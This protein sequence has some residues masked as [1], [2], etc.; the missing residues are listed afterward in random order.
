[1]WKRLAGRLLSLRDVQMDRLIADRDAALRETGLDE[2]QVW[3]DP[4]TGRLETS[5]SMWKLDT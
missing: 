1:M 5:I 4:D 3:E 2:W